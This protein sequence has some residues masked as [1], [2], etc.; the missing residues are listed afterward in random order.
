LPRNEINI[1]KTI[2]GKVFD[3][4][5]K[6]LLCKKG[7]VIIPVNPDKLRGNSLGKKSGSK[8]IKYMIE[9]SH[10]TPSKIAAK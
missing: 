9:M 7:I 3:M 6:K 10:I 4:R 1:E 2:N 5:C 8:P